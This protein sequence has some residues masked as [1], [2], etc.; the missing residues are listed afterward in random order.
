MEAALAAWAFIVANKA[1][2]LGAA[3]AV[4]E[5]LALIPAV[6]SNSIFEMVVGF[7][8]KLSGKEA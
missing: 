8:K 7:I 4:S 3:L 2:L 6:K 5:A 1:V